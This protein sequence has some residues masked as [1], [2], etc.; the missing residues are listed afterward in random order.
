MKDRKKKDTIAHPEDSLPHFFLWRQL[1]FLG[2]TTMASSFDPSLLAMGAA[3]L[4]AAAALALTQTDWASRKLLS[5]ERLAAKRHQE[6]RYR[7]QQ[8]LEQAALRQA[9]ARAG[10]VVNYSPDDE[11]LQTKLLSSPGDWK[12]LLD[13][14]ASK[15]AQLEIGKMVLHGSDY[16]LWLYEGTQIYQLP[17]LTFGLALADRLEQAITSTTLCF[18]SDA[19]TGEG[20]RLLSN[21]L[22]ATQAPVTVRSTP[23][24][25]CRLAHL[26]VTE[27]SLPQWKLERILW[28]LAKLETLRTP[29]E[30]TVLITVPTSAA[31]ILL[32]LLQKLFPDERHVFL[33]TGC[34]RAVTLR[35]KERPRSYVPDQLHSVM[36]STIPFTTPLR[37]LRSSQVMPPYRAAL[38]ALASADVVEAWMSACDAF[39][40]LKDED[41]EFLPL[42]FQLDYLFASDYDQ[43]SPAF[44]ST[45]TLWQFVTGSRSRQV[46]SETMDA[47]IS[48][49]RDTSW[50]TNVPEDKAMAHAVFQHK[51]ILIP[52]K[53]LLD[54]VQP[55]EHW[56]LKAATKR[57]CACCLPDDDDKDDGPPQRYVDGK[58]AFAFDP[59]KFTGMM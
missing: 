51:R 55:S 21:L 54:T 32:S 7:W 15:K 38:K 20:S 9:Y 36:E 35:P 29:V 33:Y 42:V 5:P 16:H 2:T 28:A 6:Y 56:T 8:A 45:R 46:P 31:A 41:T 10:G 50:Q 14:I 27:P 39:F 19:T 47:L 17:L 58:N 23:F 26:I 52:N 44:W 13:R 4:T 48:V 59:S 11:M 34:L 22:Q 37:P 57:G 30:S 1:L 18:V 43:G 24:W 25:L 40:Q 3:G 49:L 53:T 12:D